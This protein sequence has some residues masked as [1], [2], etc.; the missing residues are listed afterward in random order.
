MRWHIY[1]CLKTRQS[2]ELSSTLTRTRHSYF[3]KATAKGPAEV[4]KASVGQRVCSCVYSFAPRAC[5]Y[6]HHAI[7][8]TSSTRSLVRIMLQ[9]SDAVDEL[10]IRV[11][12]GRHLVALDNDGFSDPYVECVLCDDVGHPVP[13]AVT[14]RTRYIEKTLNPYWNEVLVLGRGK[15]MHVESMCLRLT[16]KGV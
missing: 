3:R 4:S 7:L 13:G 8:R 1:E 6:N 9:L 15:G 16:V 14:L 12:E 11:V 5:I 10:R 2:N